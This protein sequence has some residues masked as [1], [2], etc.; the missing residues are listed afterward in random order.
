[1]GLM[2]TRRE[3]GHEWMTSL[4]HTRL[5]LAGLPLGR[6]CREEMGS[7]AGKGIMFHLAPVL[8][9]SL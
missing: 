8:S 3:L 9:K 1:M 6:Q 2:R 5:K 4:T 7:M